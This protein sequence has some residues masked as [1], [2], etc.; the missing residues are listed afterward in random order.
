MALFGKNPVA[1]L[2]T[3]GSASVAR[4]SSLYYNLS[5][6][7]YFVAYAPPLPPVRTPFLSSQQELIPMLLT[8]TICAEKQPWIVKQIIKLIQNK[9]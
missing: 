4:S 1:L 8:F 3:S 5:V 9:V 2:A 6:G 7:C